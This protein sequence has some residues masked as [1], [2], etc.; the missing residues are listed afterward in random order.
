MMKNKL[1]YFI[2][3]TKF[4][5]FFTSIY[6]FG[7][8]LIFYRLTQNL[9]LSGVLFSVSNV[10][11][12]L[13]IVF[14][15]PKFRNKDP[16]K[17][18]SFSNFLLFLFTIVMVFLYD[19]FNYNLYYY[20]FMHC[21]I[22]MLEEIDNTFQYAVIPML[23]E[24]K[25]LYKVNSINGMLVNFTTIASPLCTYLFSKSIDFKYL[26]IVFSMVNL[27]VSFLLSTIKTENFSQDL[28]LKSSSLTK[29]WRKIV[30]IVVRNYDILF[31]I[32]SAV[33]INFIFSFS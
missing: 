7:F 23:S 13:I 16:I 5:S 30:N 29:E 17:I 6:N 8:L 32:L 2:F 15:V 14:I 33:I 10:V 11:N 22:L 28:S 25:N 9:F 21:I 20:F 24:K 19:H 4:Q 26:L 18:S 3:I 27:I 31:C 12:K 1:F